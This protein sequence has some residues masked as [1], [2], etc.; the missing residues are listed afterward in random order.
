MG[1]HVKGPIPV[2]P[3]PQSLWMGCLGP[4]PFENLLGKGKPSCGEGLG[5][6]PRGGSMHGFPERRKSCRASLEAARGCPLPPSGYVPCAWRGPSL[7]PPT[8]PAQL[9]QSRRFALLPAV[10][11]IGSGSDSDFC[12][13]RGSP[14]PPF[15]PAVYLFCTWRERP[16]GSSFLRN[17]GRMEHPRLLWGACLL[18][19]DSKPAF[20]LGVGEEEE[21]APAKPANCLF[22]PGADAC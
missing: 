10:I 15:S 9:A 3:T 22:L 2:R 12:V 5:F 6:S 11:G 1:S 4:F 19:G 7:N 14:R 17:P 18:R 20:Q 21:G 13:P 16:F 8:C